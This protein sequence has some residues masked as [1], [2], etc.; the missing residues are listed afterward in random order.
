MPDRQSL[1]EFLTALFVLTC[2]EQNDCEIVVSRRSIGRRLELFERARRSPRRASTTPRLLRVVADF[3]FSFQR[4]AEFHFGRIRCCSGEEGCTRDCY[5]DRSDAGVRTPR[6]LETR[7][8]PAVRSPAASYN[9]PTSFH[10]LAD[11]HRYERSSSGMASPGAACDLSATSEP[12]HG[13][14]GRVSRASGADGT[15]AKC[16][17][18][19]SNASSYRP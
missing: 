3:G 12:Q 10:E 19:W 15:G 4:A 17:V 9:S 11:G 8:S 7:F 13:L 16:S 14:F 6:L 2:F 5:A 1:H 18:Y